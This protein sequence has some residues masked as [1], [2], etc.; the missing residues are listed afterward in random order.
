V[1]NTALLDALKSICERVCQDKIDKNISD[2][3]YKNLDWGKLVKVR[4]N[5]VSKVGNN[6]YD[7]RDQDSLKRRKK[8]KDIRTDA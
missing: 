2:P 4:N 5:F 7:N 3:R 1:T 6:L 8:N